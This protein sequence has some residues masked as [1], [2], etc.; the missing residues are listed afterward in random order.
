[1][2]DKE[3]V[4][5][6]EKIKKLVNEYDFSKYPLVLEDESGRKIN[7]PLGLSDGDVYLKVAVLFSISKLKDKRIKEG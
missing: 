7:Y 5:E 2:P 4:L 6:F 3:K 1:M